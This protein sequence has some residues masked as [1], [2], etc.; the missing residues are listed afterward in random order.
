MGVNVNNNDES[1]QQ[2]P[3]QQTL[4]QQQNRRDGPYYYQFCDFNQNLHFRRATI[5]L[6]PGTRIQPS[7]MPTADNT[8]TQPDANAAA[9]LYGHQV[10]QQQQTAA[11]ATQAGYGYGGA[12]AQIDQPDNIIQLISQRMN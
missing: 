5:N 2:L 8:G 6:P 12:A 1:Q 7:I 9:T 3:S 11:A 10:Y 4:P